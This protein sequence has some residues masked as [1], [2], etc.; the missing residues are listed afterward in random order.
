MTWFHITCLQLIQLRQL[1]CLFLFGLR[2]DNLDFNVRYD[3]KNE[4]TFLSDYLA[5]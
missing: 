5:R 1:G 4:K 3:Y 2:E